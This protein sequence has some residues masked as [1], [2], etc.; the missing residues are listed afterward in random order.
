MP[1]LLLQ[2]EHPDSRM[3]DHKSYVS[4][5]RRSLQAQLQLPLP[6]SQLTALRLLRVSAWSH[7]CL[8]VRTV[9]AVP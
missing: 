7:G 6:P 1:K 4:V 3:F 2:Q 5:R 9:E 8:L